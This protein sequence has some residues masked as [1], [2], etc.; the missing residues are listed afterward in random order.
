MSDYPTTFA[1][2]HGGQPYE[3]ATEVY[4]YVRDRGICAIAAEVGIAVETLRRAL[5]K[6]PI[7]RGTA[8]KLDRFLDRQAT[9]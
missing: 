4:P 2:R 9:S 5:T 1:R 7:Y 6:E 3:R 8:K